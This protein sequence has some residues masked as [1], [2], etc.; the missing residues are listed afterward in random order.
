M[1]V[2]LEIKVMTPMRA[3]VTYT[4]NEFLTDI[5]QEKEFIDRVRCTLDD[6]F[7]NLDLKLMKDVKV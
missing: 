6:A 7:I 3:K 1:D 4:F 5:N 2:F